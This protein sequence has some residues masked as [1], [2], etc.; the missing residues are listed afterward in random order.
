LL[1]QKKKNKAQRNEM[2]LLR[3]EHIRKCKA[4]ESEH[5]DEILEIERRIKQ[6]LCKKDELVMRLKQQLTNKNIRI[7]QIETLM[8]S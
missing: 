3:E 6:T 5:G 2:E 7:Q 8:D 4:L 1:I